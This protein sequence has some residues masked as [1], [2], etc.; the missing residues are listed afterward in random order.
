MSTS[1]WPGKLA[2]PAVFATA[3]NLARAAQSAGEQAAA[4][5]DADPSL[6]SGD[7]GNAVWTLIIFVILLVVLGK[8]AWR[9]ILTALQ[10][11][12]EFIRD[13]L[14]QAKKDREQSEARLAEIEQRL[15]TAGDEATAI[16]DQG[17]RNAEAVKRKAQQDAHAEADAML[18]RAKREISLAR[19]TAVKE[20]YDLTAA[21]ATE[22]ASRII[23][24]E[25]D[26]K[27][28]ERLIAESIEKIAGDGG[29][30]KS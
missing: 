1:S 10:R 28:H 30:G 26:A 18:E 24:Q 27:Q 17:R 6:F 16:V 7:L 15:H 2:G 20:L 19:D 23:G 8:F 25:L 22:A 4:H 21:L 13:S 9:P 5:G 14:N 29:N 11:R 12:E 3:A